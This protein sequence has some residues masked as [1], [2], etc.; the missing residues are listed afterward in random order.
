MVFD[1]KAYMKEY[2]EKNREKKKEYKKQYY[3]T[4]AGKKTSRISNWKQRGIVY[5]DYNSLYDL[6]ISVW[7]CEECNVELVEGS[8]GNNRKCLDHDHITGQFRN[9]LC[10]TCNLRRR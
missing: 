8:Y 10:N 5:D 7:N 6:Y 4:E 2:R 1:R 9:V 3:Q